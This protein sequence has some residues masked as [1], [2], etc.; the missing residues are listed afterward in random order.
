MSKRLNPKKKEEEEAFFLNCLKAKK[1][2]QNQLV[3]QRNRKKMR[4]TS[5]QI[6]TEKIWTMRA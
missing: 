4:K 2:N 1:M 3:S 5:T 6:T